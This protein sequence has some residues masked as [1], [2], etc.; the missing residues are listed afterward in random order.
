AF[1]ENLHLRDRYEVP[2]SGGA[3]NPNLVLEIGYGKDANDIDYHSKH[4][5]QIK[6]SPTT[7]L[8]THYKYL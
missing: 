7:V 6:G 1:A 2:P 3:L 5:S 8:V 4:L